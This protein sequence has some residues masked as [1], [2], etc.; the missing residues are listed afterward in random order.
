MKRFAI[1]ALISQCILAGCVEQLPFMTAKEPDFNVDSATNFD[2]SGQKQKSDL[3]EQL[4]ARRSL[5]ED[6][7]IYNTVAQTALTASARSAEAELISA[8]LR[9][10]AQ[11]KNWLP[12]L[13]PTVSL[14]DLGD[15][16][17]GLLIEQV[18]FDNGRRKFE[19][20]FAAADVEVAAVNLSIDQ[21]TRVE[22]ALNLYIQSQLGEEQARFGEKALRQM[23]EFERVV[24]GR[25]N[26]GVSD[27]SDLRVVQSKIAGIRS[28]VSTASESASTARAELY[29]LTGQDF[30]VQPQKLVIGTPPEAAGF[31]RVLLAQ[32][33]ANRSIARAEV[34]RASLLPQISASGNLTTGGSG[35]S[36]GAGLTAGLGQPLGL[37]T[38]SAIK[39]IEATKE[40]ARRQISEAEEDSRRAYSRHLQRLTSF[41]RQ[42]EET[43]RLARTSYETYKLFKAQFEA[44]Q[45]TV[46]DV[47][48]IYEEYTRRELARIEAKYEVIQI[49]IEMARDQGLLADG[50]RI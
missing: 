25:V 28:G 46:L 38:P 44:G 36:S 26:G 19:R 10:E 48:N 22:T 15:M 50:D 40:I 35:V 34:E 37:G 47:V 29:A 8:K 13:G 24:Q 41:R 32:S 16:V 43:T 7:S 33:E 45:R 6:T 30:H 21:N 31:M 2:Q 42:E 3:I 14:T 20:E 18:L 39:A 5:L 4:K 17:A 11:S 9:A 23:G 12:T 1:G 49:Q 27:H